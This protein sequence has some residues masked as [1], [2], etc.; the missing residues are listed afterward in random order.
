MLHDLILALAGHS[1]DIFIVKDDG[2]YEV[3]DDLGFFHPCE[4]SIVEELLNIS[5]CYKR[6]K[7]FYT[8]YDTV[9]ISK[10]PNYRGGLYLSSLAGAL[11]SSV[12]VY[13]TSVVQ[14]E[15]QIIDD[16]ELPLSHLLNVLQP[17]APLLAALASLVAEIEEKKPHGCKILEVL[18]K[19]SALSVSYIRDTFV[20]IEQ[21]VHSV[22]YDQLTHWM[23]Y[24]ILIDPH[25]ELFIR[26][27]STCID[28]SSS[29]QDP[30]QSDAIN[31]AEFEAPKI[32]NNYNL[33]IDMLP[34]HI[35]LHI[36]G[37]ILFIGEAILVFEREGKK[38]TGI[39]FSS[40][41]SRI[42]LVLK[43]KEK[44]YLQLLHGL[45]DAPFSIIE[46]SKVVE[47][48]R[49]CVSQEV[50]KLVMDANL[51]TVL[52]DLKAVY[53]LGRGELYQALIPSLTHFMK[54]AG[55]TNDFNALFQLAGRQVLLED[56]MLSKFTLKRKSLPGDKSST[57]SSELSICS[58]PG[59]SWN[60][61]KIEYNAKWPLH[62]LFTS[63]VQDR[64]NAIFNFLLDMRRAQY[65]LQQLWIVQM[66]TKNDNKLD[67]LPWT[68]RHQMSLLID[69]I[70]Y[71]L[72]V[73]VLESHHWQLIGEIDKT[74]DY[75]HLATLHHNF[76]E[77]V[78]AQCFMSNGLI[79]NR[80]L[81]LLNLVNKFC[82]ILEEQYNT[83]VQ[84]RLNFVQ[85][86]QDDDWQEEIK[87]LSS[88]FQRDCYNLFF[89]LSELSV[90]QRSQYTS[91][92]VMRIDYNKFYSSN[93][94]TFRS[95][96]DAERAQ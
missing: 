3:V 95:A 44:E 12:K 59:K 55:S 87:M 47:T 17:L 7:N 78:A 42:G 61:L 91:Q 93:A 73:D 21:T 32:Y 71:Y 14:V 28:N 6:I 90:H 20:R 88:V 10:D 72:Q 43:N 1:G 33:E 89:L 39:D 31:L 81:I 30:S 27:V 50:C 24:G 51:V 53:F 76:L 48:I 67:S 77:S 60:T 80:L 46:F 84:Q 65:R 82:T 66:K 19:H 26:T 16:P 38:D 23:L 68:S 62:K 63:R 8:E 2:T 45:A 85:Q 11:K 57:K 9:Q 83:D 70:Q 96:F 13:D 22:L 56:E 49:H 52:H 5:S 36:A 75:Q 4:V 92:L 74:S 25:N 41:P 69:N 37:K 29:N 94:K 34:S 40:V 79:W 54:T 58:L 35:P 15:Q 86:K 18:H 64:Y